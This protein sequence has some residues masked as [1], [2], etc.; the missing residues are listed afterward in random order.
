MGNIG[1]IIEQEYRNRVVKKSF[2]LLTILMPILF[3]ALIF[4]PLWL[5]SIESDEVQNIAVDDQTGL[6]GEVFENMSNSSFNFILLDTVV[7][8]NVEMV[9]SSNSYDAMIIVSADLAKNPNAISYYGEKMASGSLVSVV[10]NSLSDYVEKQ[11]LAS[12]NIPDIEKIIKD[13]HTDVNM[14]TYKFNDA[15]GVSASNSDIASLIGILATVLIYMFIFTSGS[16]VMQSIIQEKVN[17]VVE[18]MICTVRPWQLMWGKIIAVALVSLTQM[19]IWLV[20]TGALVYGGGSMTGF[21]V[22]GSAAAVDTAAVPTADM[23]EFESI[24]YTVTSINWFYIATL[25]VIYFVLGYLLYASLFAAV[26]SAV[27]N[28]ADTNQFLMPITILVLF[29]LYAGMY[30]AENP[31]GPLAFWCSLIPLTSPIVM[32]VRAPFEVPMWQIITSISLLF[33]TLLFTV[34]FSSKIYRVGI[35]MYGKKPSWKEIIKWLKY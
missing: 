11:K 31:D 5:A 24:I 33:V 35:L 15:G 16:M 22:I 21:D 34:W 8:N 4:V 2:I 18:V 6:Y 28:E 29:A 32:M 12:Y 20:M 27:D 13:S 17:R 25:F 19:L 26:G 14:A 10:E 23:S 3:A 9:Q 7:G 30:S 1:L